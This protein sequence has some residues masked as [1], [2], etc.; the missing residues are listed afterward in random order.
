[1]WRGG[2]PR[3]MA[4]SAAPI[5]S[6]SDLRV[7]YGDREVLHGLTFDV[8]HGE[9]LVIIGGLGSGKNT[10]LRNFVGLEKAS[11]RQVVVKG[12]DINKAGGNETDAIPKRNGGAL[13]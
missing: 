3:R 6:A 4:V 11:F 2:T 8:R 9:T 10:M 1:M 5:I 13:H 7:A 12:G